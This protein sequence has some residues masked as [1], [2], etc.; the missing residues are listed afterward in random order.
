MATLI[1]RWDF[2][3]DTEGFALTQVTRLSS[4]EMQT[5]AT[6]RNTKVD[7]YITLSGATY[8][9]LGVPASSTVNSVI[10]R[11]NHRC[12]QYNVVDYVRWDGLFNGA[13]AIPLA[14]YA[15]VTAYAVAS[16]SSIPLTGATE[17]TTFS[18][19]IDSYCDNANNASA[20]SEIRWD[21]IELEVDYTPPIYDYSG[22]VAIT[23]SAVV[24]VSG[25]KTGR[26]SLEIT[27]ASAVEAA[28]KK[29]G[30]D[31]IAITASGSTESTGRKQASDAL[32]ITAVA[33][34]A[35]S[36]KKA[37]S[38]T[39]TITTG[40][41]VSVN[42]KK[43]S[44]GSLEIATAAEAAAHGEKQAAEAIT[45]TASGSVSAD[46]KQT[47][48]KTGTI[49]IA[50]GSAVAL[51]GKVQR[52]GAV[53]ITGPSTAEVSE[54]KKAASGPF[55]IIGP[56]TAE[57]AGN[58]AVV[59]AFGITEETQAAAAGKKASD[60]PI[61]LTAAAEVSASGNKGAYDEL[62]IIA[63]STLSVYGG[64]SAV[65]RLEITAQAMVNI[66]GAKGAAGT[67]ALT[68]AGQTVVAGKKKAAGAV[69]VEGAAN[70]SLAGEKCTS[71][72]I[73]ILVSS[74]VDTIGA[75]K[76]LLRDP[77]VTADITQ[78]LVTIDLDEIRPEIATIEYEL[79][80]TIT[81]YEL[82]TFSEEHYITTEVIGV[83]FIGATVKL[84]ATFP[85]TAGDLAGL[86][87]VKCVIT[88]SDRN[89]I[90][91]IEGEAIK[92]GSTVDQFFTY[93]NIPA[94]GVGDLSYAWSGN[95]GEDII[96]LARKGM[97]RVWQ[98]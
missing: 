9:S 74:L 16:S 55:E 14:D 15:G 20:V 45:I 82:Q 86:T 1:K 22:S 63:G 25:K 41:A 13:S 60:S 32:G 67:T 49:S 10:L 3:T 37:A 47:Y 36:G 89:I 68:A 53:A 87:N 28:G 11:A 90:D 84:N 34:T 19:Q 70:L 91:T 18:L 29:N 71:G 48:T 7:G 79:L 33:E 46:G 21:Y 64:G 54:G 73:A 4:G 38:E 35:A 57:A 85:S 2:T 31:T 27:A 40:A 51:A 5:I 39:A 76:Y 92:E 78:W 72:S 75:Q 66:T 26:A 43:V 52:F 59:G 97:G 88:D 58:K 61:S 8:A 12:A 50:A 93:Y 69:N 23:A 81:A 6:G 83:P 44:S 30:T 62:V 65:G 56:S 94:T 95:L 24:S 96:L 42:G 98:E 80:L 77:T 17:E